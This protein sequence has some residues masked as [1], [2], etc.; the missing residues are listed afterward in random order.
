MFRRYK[1]DKHGVVEM[2]WEDFKKQYA[3]KP[4][5][6]RRNNQR[7]SLLYR[8]LLRYAQWSDPEHFPSKKEQERRRRQNRQPQ[9]FVGPYVARGQK[10]HVV[11]FI[12]DER[13]PEGWGYT[14][15]CD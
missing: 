5:K 2:H 1:R 14:Y 8:L 10:V 11:H 6:R 4:G 12:N 13:Y 9:V 7:P 3:T 15:Q